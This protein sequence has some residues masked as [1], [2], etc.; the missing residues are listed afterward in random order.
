M[1]LNKIDTLID[2]FGHYDM[3][4]ECTLNYLRGV[5]WLTKQ[6]SIKLRYLQL[7]LHPPR[8]VDYP[9]KRQN[10]DKDEF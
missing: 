2:L 7:H 9:I 4:G 10:I 8:C 1:M 5:D 3:P 6:P